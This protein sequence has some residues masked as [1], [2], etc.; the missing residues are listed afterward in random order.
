MKKTTDNFPLKCRI[1]NRKRGTERLPSILFPM[2]K[3][4]AC[5]GF[6]GITPIRS[7]RPAAEYSYKTMI[8]SLKLFGIST[9]RMNTLQK[10]DL[11]Q[12]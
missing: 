8:N 12:K 1:F 9:F 5:R 6:R 10:S 2:S 4:P 11:I 7:V 3:G